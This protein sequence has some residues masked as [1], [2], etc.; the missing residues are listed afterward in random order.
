LPDVTRISVGTKFRR[1]V[2]TAMLRW[3]FLFCL[4]LALAGGAFAAD[5]PAPAPDPDGPPLLLQAL[6]TVGKNFD[7]W[8]FTETRVV[9][10][11]KGQPEPE[12]VVRFDPSKPYAEQY[13]PLKVE[14]KPPTK[15]QRKDFRRQ[16]EKRGEKLAKDEA[17][18]RMP[19]RDIRFE[20]NGSTASIDLAHATVVEENA[21]SVTYELPLRN[22]G[23]G[24]LPVEKFQ[25]FAR[26]NRASGAFENISLRVR[27][28]FRLKLVVK[29]KSGAVSVDFARVD[30]AHDPVAVRISGDATASIL[31]LTVGGKFAVT[32][33]DFHRVTPYNERFGVKIGPLKA[34]NF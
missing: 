14:G 25:L 16:G 5:A 2:H 30:Q 10:D 20:L 13:E 31:F 29:I 8:A 4:P 6:N 23:R 18:G 32:R 17:E 1:D 34:L 28:S 15:H 19:G 9:T 22:D 33:T 11:G 3:F 26:V 27:Q 24:T 21:G 12:T 7:H